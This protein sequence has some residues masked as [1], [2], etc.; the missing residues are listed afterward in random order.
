M[1]YLADGAL[2]IDRHGVL[3]LPQLTNRH[4]VAQ[5]LDHRAVT[6]DILL[7][8]LQDKFVTFM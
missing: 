1:E 8:L 6:D 7:E 2:P 3:A 4:K 5:F